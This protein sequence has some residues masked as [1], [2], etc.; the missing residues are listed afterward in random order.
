M[1][2]NINTTIPNNNTNFTKN[3]GDGSTTDHPHP[4]QQTRRR[5]SQR[6]DLTGNL[7]IMSGNDC[8]S[9][10]NNNVGTSSPNKRGSITN[11]NSSTNHATMF[12]QQQKH[13][14][15][16]T[17]YFH[18]ILSSIERLE[19]K[20]D[21]VDQRVV[22]MDTSWN[23]FK[24]AASARTDAQ[25][26]SSSSGNQSIVADQMMTL[27]A[28]A[29]Q[30]GTPVNNNNNNNRGSGK[31]L[32]QHRNSGSG[33]PKANSKSLKKRRSTPENPLQAPRAASVSSE[34]VPPT[35]IRPHLNNSYNTT[36]RAVS[37]TFLPE[38]LLVT[39]MELV[40]W[41]ACVIEAAYVFTFVGTYNWSDGPSTG[42]VAIL[43]ATLLLNM[44]M[45][46][47]RMRVACT[48]RA[49]LV[50]TPSTV[51]ELYMSSVWFKWDVFMS[52][53]IDLL[54]L[55][56]SPV[57]FRATCL[58]RVLRGVRIPY[59]FQASNPLVPQRIVR[60]LVRLVTCVLYGH[61]FAGTV[62]MLVNFHPS[63]PTP[64]DGLDTDSAFA[65]VTSLYWAVQL[66]T[67]V[68]LGDVVM[69]NDATL[70]NR[71]MTSVFMLLGVGAYGYVISYMS[72]RLITRNR[73]KETIRQKKEKMNAMMEFYQVPWEVQKETFALYP[74]LVDACQSDFQDVIQVLPPFVQEHITY[75]V[76][77]RL[78]M[79]VPMFK[80]APE[81]MIADLT[82]SLVEELVPAG[83]A[84]MSMGDIG[85]EMF[86]VVH[87]IVEVTG[88]DRE[89]GEQIQL[90]LLQEGSWFGEV[91]ILKEAPRTA[92]VRTVTSC[93]L[94]VLSK[95]MFHQI[96]ERHASTPFVRVMEAELSQRIK[97]FENTVNDFLGS[98]QGAPGAV[99]DGNQT[100]GGD[101]TT[102]PPPPP[103]PFEECEF[104]HSTLGSNHQNTHNSNLLSVLNRRG[105]SGAASVNRESSFRFL[106]S[107]ISRTSAGTPT[108]LAGA[109]M[110]TA[111]T[112]D[113][114]STSHDVSDG[115]IELTLPQGVLN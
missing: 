11:N 23:D 25:G 99:T 108:G 105:S 42:W 27:F 114:N 14:D 55:I 76:R 56:I 100:D 13:L 95:D 4:H 37:R 107:R 47:L 88:L 92:S 86:F 41:I 54:C 28:P 62:W 71:V 110:A 64:P 68:G 40:F 19:M 48:H 36:S 81:D 94:M 33:T 66:S 30:L 16:I 85:S 49:I 67:S 73:V 89:T 43:T 51:R 75:Y 3:D 101:H 44:A 46:V 72:A 9:N 57:A 7:P 22:T 52:V 60:S 111:G 2:S 96:L 115:S 82:N 21:D 113:Q 70:Q 102:V 69:P 106:L 109:M 77:R 98:H 79:Q 39:L 26:A 59:L 74:R 83:E 61:M 34:H 8:N 93:D 87:G 84:V 112:S 12:E 45:A 78:L 63:K 97:K 24:A 5:K 31:H 104:S 29:T 35:F 32:S 1:T 50:D 10:P 103:N 6:M 17:R 80:D 15:E 20:I 38:S 18:A 91:S 90:A 65:F 53:P 58:I